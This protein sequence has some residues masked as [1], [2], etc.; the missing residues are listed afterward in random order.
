DKTI[1]PAGDERDPNPHKEAAE[2][3]SKKVTGRR[4]LQ[5]HVAL[6][7]R[8]GEC[9]HYRCGHSWECDNPG[10]HVV[11]KKAVLQ[12]LSKRPGRR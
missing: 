3:G 12:Q 4:F 1:I 10:A 6:P 9:A 2:E 5:A 7:R 11:E 8:G